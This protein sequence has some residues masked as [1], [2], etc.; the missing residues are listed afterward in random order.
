MILC[1]VPGSIFNVYVCVRIR[2]VSVFIS[3][4]VTFKPAVPNFNQI[5][6]SENAV[7]H[8]RST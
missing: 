1:S 4:L 3:S 8:R 5:F 2:A 7:V 6:F